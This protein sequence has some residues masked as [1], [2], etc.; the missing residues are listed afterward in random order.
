MVAEISSGEEVTVEEVLR[1]LE[2]KET[3]K[4]VFIFLAGMFSFHQGLISQVIMKSLGIQRLNLHY[5]ENVENSRV[6]FLDNALFY[7]TCPSHHQSPRLS[8]HSDPPFSAA[9]VFTGLQF[10]HSSPCLCPNPT[11][12]AIQ[13]LNT[14]PETVGKEEQPIPYLLFLQGGPGFECPRP[15]EGSGWILKACE[16]FRVILMDQRGTGLST[17]LTPSSMQQIKSA[18]KLADYLTHVR[19]DNIFNDAEFI[20][21]RLVPEAKPWT[22]LGQSYGG[23]CVVTYLNFAPKGLKQVLLTGGI[24]PIGNGCTADSVYRA[25]FEQLIHQNENTIRGS[26][27]TLKL[28]EMLLPFWQNPKEAG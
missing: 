20:R 10:V 14:S 22:V 19:A 27:R 7:V 9:F 23:F 24:P 18:Q 15:T 1:P 13:R 12:L 28:S 2:F 16:E 25:S 26:L 11:P 4:V 5:P 21:V 17:P 6:T 3:E 8:L